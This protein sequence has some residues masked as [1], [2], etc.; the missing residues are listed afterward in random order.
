[1]VLTTLAFHP[2]EQSTCAR[3]YTCGRQTRPQQSLENRILKIAPNLEARSLHT[4]VQQKTHLV[5]EQASFK[6]LDQM[7]RSASTCVSKY[8]GQQSFEKTHIIALIQKFSWIRL[9]QTCI[10]SC[11]SVRVLLIC[12]GSRSMRV[13]ED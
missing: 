7:E 2:A 4:A 3:R 8:A 9:Y 5:S 10:P 13:P 11:A 12:Y 6:Q 1:M